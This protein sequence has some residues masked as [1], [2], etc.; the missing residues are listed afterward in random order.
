M[1]AG[2]GIR[3]AHSVDGLGRDVYQNRWY[4]ATDGRGDANMERYERRTAVPGHSTHDSIRK[5]VTEG[6]G[7]PHSYDERV[8]LIKVSMP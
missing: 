8:R 2:L 6:H 1:A 5:V 3:R 4:V 7:I